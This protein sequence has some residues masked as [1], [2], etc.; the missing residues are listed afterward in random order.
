MSRPPAS[1]A[2]WRNKLFWWMYSRV[3][4]AAWDNALT[5]HV[6]DRL[7]TNIAVPQLQILE[8][9]SGSGLIS[10]R[11]TSIADDVVL[12][13][14]NAEMRRRLCRRLPAANVLSSTLDDIAV[15]ESVDRTVIAANVLHLVADADIA[16]RTLQKLAGPGGQ[17]LAITP[18]P[19]TSVAAVVRGIHASGGSVFQSLRFLVVHVMLV[20]FIA[21]AG[22]T[23]TRSSLTPVSVDGPAESIAGVDLL[24]NWM[25][26]SLS[27]VDDGVAFSHGS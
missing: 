18:V 25:P 14:P 15:D 24:W 20:P 5:A 11:L 22:S 16:M 12:S 10:R 1:S 13:E 6:A 3:Y 27:G 21:I 23:L 9:G 7:I 19:E 4:D 17:V 26:S 8:I 2:C